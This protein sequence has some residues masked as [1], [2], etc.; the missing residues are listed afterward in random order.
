MQ[1]SA[2]PDGGWWRTHI[3]A[4]REMWHGA[5]PDCGVRGVMDKAIFRGVIQRE[6]SATRYIKV[7]GIAARHIKVRGIEARYR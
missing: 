2:R 5:V 6:I 3:A 1:V 4:V 7:H